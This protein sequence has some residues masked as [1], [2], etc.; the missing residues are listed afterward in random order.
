MTLPTLPPGASRRQLRKAVLR[1]RLEMHRQEVRHEVLQISEPLQQ[2]REYGKRLRTGNAPL[3]LTGGVL[4]L[5]GLL[6][7]KRGWRRWARLALIVAPLL[8]RR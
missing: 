1:M 7:G 8:R 2:V 5:A 6:G 3:L 4:A